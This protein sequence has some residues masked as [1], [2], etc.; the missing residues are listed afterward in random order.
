MTPVERIKLQLIYRP[1]FMKILNV[2][3][4]QILSTL[5]ALV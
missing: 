1:H 3:Y 4:I 2:K 5:N